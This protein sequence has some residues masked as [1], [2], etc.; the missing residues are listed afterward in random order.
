MGSISLVCRL[1]YIFCLGVWVGRAGTVDVGEDATSHNPN[2]RYYTFS[3]PCLVS[4]RMAMDKHWLVFTS[5][6]NCTSCKIGSLSLWYPI[7]CHNQCI[8]GAEVYVVAPPKWECCVLD[9]NLSLNGPERP[10][11][12][13]EHWYKIYYLE[14]QPLVVNKCKSQLLMCHLQ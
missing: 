4:R 6:F 7:T 1:C 10:W 9:L 12:Q 3:C 8:R 11:E 5:L 14:K 13:R 2:N